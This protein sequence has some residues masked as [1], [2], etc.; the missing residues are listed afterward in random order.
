MQ[1]VCAFTNEGIDDNN[2][3]AKTIQ[4]ELILLMR[5]KYDGMRG[6]LTRFMHEGWGV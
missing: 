3:N 5:D 4:N 6:Q 1:A 2:K